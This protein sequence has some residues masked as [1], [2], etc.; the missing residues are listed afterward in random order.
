MLILRCKPLLVKAAEGKCVF[1]LQG[2]QVG[3]EL[4]AG[5]L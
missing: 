3:F 4:A 2:L 5:G 1:I